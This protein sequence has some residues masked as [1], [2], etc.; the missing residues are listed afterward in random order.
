MGLSYEFGFAS[1]SA[2]SVELV[3]TK[4]EIINEIQCHQNLSFLKFPLSN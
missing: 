4:I 1:Y 2:S 3:V